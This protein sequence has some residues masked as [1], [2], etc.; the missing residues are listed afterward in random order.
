MTYGIVI[1]PSVDIQDEANALRK[2]YDPKY[3]Y[4]SPHITLKYPFQM[5]AQER[6][7]TVKALEE[8][9]QET[10][11][12]QIEVTKISSFSPVS[13][14]IYL[15]VEDNEH[16]NK[17]NEKMHEGVFDAH[18]EHAFIPHITI[19]QDLPSDEYSDIYSSLRMR[20]IHFTDT[21]DRFQLCKQLEN[22]NWTVD[23]T[24]HFGKK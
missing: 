1:F 20:Q 13:N 5:D 2:R 12:F 15:K 7:E 9:A 8:I 10:E 23:K 4:I 16:L 22:G 3:P 18:R 21:I 6:D 17:L 14:A 24:F 11:P 19:A